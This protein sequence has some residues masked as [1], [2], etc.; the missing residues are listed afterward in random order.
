MKYIRTTLATDWKED[1]DKRLGG[2]IRDL[3][4]SFIPKDNPGYE[5]KFHLIKEWLIEFD[6]EELPDREIAL[7]CNG[8][9]IFAGPTREN[10]GFWLDTNMKYPDFPGQE[11]ASAVFER[12]WA[13]AGIE[14][15]S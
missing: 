12:Y 11:I 5:G 1:G 8:T 3:L 2:K 6:E 4:L 7:D 10:Y 15:T 9:I 14:E 13:Q